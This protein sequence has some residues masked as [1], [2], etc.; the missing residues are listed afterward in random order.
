MFTLTLKTHFEGKGEGEGRVAK[1]FYF[2]HGL[3]NA[4]GNIA[5]KSEMKKESQRLHFERQQ[6]RKAQNHQVSQ[7]SSGAALIPLESVNEDSYFLNVHLFIVN[8]LFVAF[9]S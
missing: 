2:P 9:F 4:N 7:E 5:R 8:I 6:K 3:F 1:T